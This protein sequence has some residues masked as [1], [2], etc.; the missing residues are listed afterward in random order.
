MRAG[1]EETRY[2]VKIQR[3][4]TIA[5]GVAVALVIGVGGAMVLAGQF[6]AGELTV[7]AAYIK[8]LL[9]PVEKI[10]DLVSTVMRGLIASEQVQA[11]LEQAPAVREAAS[12]IQLRHVRGILEVRDVWFSYRETAQQHATILRGVN[13]RLAPGK[14]TAITGESGCG[15]STMLNLLLRLHEP[16]AGEIYL[17]GIPYS[18]IS[19][20]S[21]RSQMAVML[22]NTHL[23]AGTLREAL[24]HHVEHVSDKRLWEALRFVGLDHHVRA[25][26]L[27][28]DA[29]LG[30]EGY[31][32]SGGQ[33]QRLSL[34][35][36]FLLD[37]PML[38]LDEP[39]SNVDA[40]SEAVILNAL[41]QIRVGKT[42]LVITHQPAIIQRADEV[43]VLEQGRLANVDSFARETRIPDWALQSETASLP[44]NGMLL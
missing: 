21:L 33:R 20:H 41:D 2:A 29:T 10:N 15:K 30:E 23:F 18:Q 6:S 7:F 38:L 26:P 17:D 31:N 3:T 8:K 39:A 14:L 40:A 11:L 36:A 4:L 44:R 25:L 32:F 34:A 28:L 13:L 24:T 35:R 27:G 12:A 43:Y 9:R 5:E 16:A 1:V 22:Q 19:P 37:R 42:C